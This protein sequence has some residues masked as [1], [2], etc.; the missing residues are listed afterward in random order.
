MTHNDLP[1]DLVLSEAQ[2]REVIDR[3]TR[4]ERSDDGVSVTI[5]RQVAD[6]LNIDPGALQQ[7]LGDVVGLP[8]K[9]RPMRGWAKRRFMQLCRASDQVLPG[10][11]RLAAGIVVGAS[12]GWLSAHVAAGL[13]A[14]I[15]GVSA[16]IGSSS[17]IDLPVAAALIV[18]T[19]ANSLGHRYS[20]GFRRY[21]AETIGT[22][23]AFAVAWMVTFGA[24]TSDLMTW[25]ALATSGALLL[26]WLIIPRQAPGQR[27]EARQRL[28]AISAP[29]T[30]PE[31]RADDAPKRR[32]VGIFNPLVLLELS[33]R[34][35]RRFTIQEMT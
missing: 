22:W 32:S 31:P 17:F 24:A 1:D 5:L 30:D 25:V 3:A 19:I 26:G 2:F 34:Q 27:F 23:G 29:R 12:L 15:G 13:Q 6:E 33:L 10:R 8:D 35:A 16:S 21:C 20:G 18:L 11:A 28:R 9:Q 4:M 14:I 7:A